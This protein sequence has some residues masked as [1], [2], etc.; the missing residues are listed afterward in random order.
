L[1]H[2]QH[3]TRTDK[4]IAQFTGNPADRLFSGSGAECNLG[5]ADTTIE[6]CT[7]KR[8]GVLR[9][10]NRNDGYQANLTNCLK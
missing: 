1:F 6:E 10:V 7:G 3:S 5:T 2:R 4:H 8:H 9:P